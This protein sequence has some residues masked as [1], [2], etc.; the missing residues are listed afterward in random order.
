MPYNGDLSSSRFFPKQIRKAL[1]NYE[2]I[3]LH[4]VDLEDDGIAQKSDYELK[5]EAINSVMKELEIKARCKAWGATVAATY[6][7]YGTVITDFEK[8]ERD[9]V[10][11][12]A[13]NNIDLSVEKVI[14]WSSSPIPRGGI[15][16]NDISSR[17]RPFRLPGSSPLASLAILNRPSFMIS[18]F[19]QKLDLFKL[20]RA[21]ALEA[22]EFDEVPGQAEAEE[23][24]FWQEV[25]ERAEAAGVLVVQD[26]STLTED[27]EE[28][29]VVTVE[30]T[31]DEQFR[32]IL[33]EVIEEHI[34][35][36]SSELD[37][38]SAYFHKN[39]S[40]GFLDIDKLMDST[41]PTITDL[42]PSNGSFT[43]NPAPTIS[44]VITDDAEGIGVDSENIIMQIDGAKLA[45][46]F[47]SES[48]KVSATPP[49]PLTDGEHEVNLT[50]YDKAGNQAQG[51]WSFTVDT[52]PANGVFTVLSKLVDPEER[53][54]ASVRAEADEPVTYLAEVFKVSG[55]DDDEDEDRIKTPIK[56]YSYA[57]NALTQSFTFAWDGRSSKGRMAGE[58]NYVLR[59]T[60]FDRAKN[61]T[62]FEF[63]VKVDD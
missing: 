36:P 57:S 43:D 59:I 7:S 39:L 49:S 63:K 3:R 15:P 60:L 45:C 31:S 22:G 14:N 41:A 26:E 56:I 11:R 28:M 5:K 10:A 50:A 24:A 48:G 8:F 53:K 29:Y 55:D 17:V 33:K 62:E 18:Q 35:N 58:G 6:L 61:E 12:G 19:L 9:M 32:D 2:M 54:K 51:D 40:E 46:N 16:Y 1:V 47:D 52:T 21:W 42:T 44:A 34:K 20:E 25:S 27:G 30:I 13:K 23:Y 38:Q 37:R 4:E